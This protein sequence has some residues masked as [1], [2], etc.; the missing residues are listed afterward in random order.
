MNRAR[1]QRCRPFV[2]L[3]V[4]LAGLA[5]AGCFNPFSPRIAPI[6]GASKP[7]PAP[8]TASGVLRLFEWCYNSKAIGEY[9]EI[10][11]DDYRFYFSPL[12]SSGAEWRDTP[13]TREDELISATNLFVGGSATE[14]AASSIRLSFDRNFLVYPDRYYLRYPDN[15]SR[16]PAGVWHKEIRTTVTLQIGTDDGNS[17]EIKGHATFY[18]VR[19]DSA[20]IPEEMRLKGFGPDPNRWYIRRWDDDT[21]EEGSGS[22]ASTSSRVAGRTAR[23]RGKSDGARR[24]AGT[25]ELQ[26]MRV[27]SWGEIKV[28]YLHPAGSMASLG[29]PAP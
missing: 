22:L 7:A 2:A 11:S 24:S 10:F 1:F 14:P 21:A 20:L 28:Y 19:G 13:Y 18:M 3:G 29:P 4:L 6:L 27:A 5:L 23:W 26:D 9:R 17:L 16:D 25:Y 8:V 15:T 12:D